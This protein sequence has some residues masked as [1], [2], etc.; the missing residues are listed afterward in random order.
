MVR[1][2]VPAA[3][4]GAGAHSPVDSKLFTGNAR[5]LAQTDKKLKE[6]EQHA[7][8]KTERD[9]GRTAADLE[10]GRLVRALRSLSLSRTSCPPCEE[11]FMESPDLP[12]WTRIG[13]IN[14]V[15]DDEE[16]G[17]SASGVVKEPDGFV[18]LI[19][20]FGFRIGNKGQRREDRLGCYQ[21]GGSRWPPSARRLCA[22]AYLTPELPAALFGHKLNMPKKVR[23]IS[24]ITEVVWVT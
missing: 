18:S 9:A 15:G 13:A 7:T 8:E 5:S 3:T 16:T 17:F 11:R 23:C 19:A 4:C 20:E 1:C 6:M 2:A 22:C 14:S 12:D 21:P 24:N 10:R